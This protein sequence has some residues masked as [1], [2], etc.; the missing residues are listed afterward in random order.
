MK[1]IDIDNNMDCWHGL[2]EGGW[3]FD[4]CILSGPF[5]IRA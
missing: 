1:K 2:Q 5:P 3:G 4:T